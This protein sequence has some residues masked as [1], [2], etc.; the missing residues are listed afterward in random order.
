MAEKENTYFSDDVTRAFDAAAKSL[1]ATGEG[2][3][4]GADPMYSIRELIKNNVK[5]REDDIKKDII[6]WLEPMA[7]DSNP[8]ISLLFK[9]ARDS[10]DKNYDLIIKR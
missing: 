4:L 7:K 8:G 6:E 10:F 5:N 9:Q 1:K 3:L 2:E